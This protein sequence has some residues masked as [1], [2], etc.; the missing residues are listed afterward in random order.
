MDRTGGHLEGEILDG[1]DA[2]ELLRQAL[3]GQRAHFALRCK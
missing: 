3:D 2:S 1:M